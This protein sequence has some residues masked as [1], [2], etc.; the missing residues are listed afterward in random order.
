MRRA[1]K[2][3]QLII[4][5]VEENPNIPLE[6][7]IGQVLHDTGVQVTPQ[8]VDQVFRV[9]HKSK[10]N[11]RATLIIFTKQS[12]RD[13]VYR[14]RFEIKN[15]P[16]CSKIWINEALDDLQRQERAELKALSELAK[17]EGYESRV[18]RDTLV[19]QSINYTHASINKLPS[20]ITLKR[21]YLKETEDS[22]YFTP[23]KI[24]YM[25]NEYSTL[26]QGYT[27]RMATKSEDADIA[28][29]ILQEYRPRKC[30][31]LAKRIKN[32]NWTEDDEKDEM[33]ALAKK[34]FQIPEYRLKL[35]QSEGKRLV[36]CTKDKKWAGGVTL[37]SKEVRENQK[38]LP[39]NNKLEK[40]LM[41]KRKTILDN[42]DQEQ[43]SDSDTDMP[44]PLEGD[45]M[46][47]T[48]PEDE[49]Q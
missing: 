12:T 46:P 10:T 6:S 21:A 37:W 3:K 22:L 16:A 34:K 19:V 35:I 32:L 25:G 14:A 11:P 43:N 15:N 33:T 29:Q 28:Q 26:E 13:K 23:T 44:P 20:I 40:I 36:K 47:K 27:H 48:N 39:G 24:D 38:K 8:E 41:Q 30:K 7:L 9:G 4:E 1:D 17:E 2:K 5:R 45:D 42:I 49:Q 31:A 18:V